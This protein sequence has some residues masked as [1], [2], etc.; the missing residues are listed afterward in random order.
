M[1]CRA[2]QHAAVSHL[3]KESRKEGLF[4]KEVWI[5]A[6]AS[7]FTFFGIAATQSSYVD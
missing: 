3:A 5:V 2:I 4:S 1:F 6:S 7:A